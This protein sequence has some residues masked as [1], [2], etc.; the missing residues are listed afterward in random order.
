MRV[1]CRAMFGLAIGG[2]GSIV[3]GA[4]FT[5]LHVRGEGKGISPELVVVG[6]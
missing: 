3:M 4:L 2:E 6:L 5:I 1:T